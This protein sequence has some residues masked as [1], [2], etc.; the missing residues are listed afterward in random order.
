MKW[1][2]LLT[3]GALGLALFAAHADAHPRTSVSLGINLGAPFYRPWY[4]PPVYY[5]PYPIYYAPA[6][7]V[8]YEPAPIV[9][10]PAPIVVTS[11]PATVAAP[12]VV[13]VPSQVHLTSSSATSV[14]A[15][16]QLLSHGD[17]AVRRDAVMELGRQKA[18]N[19]VDAL[20]A[21]LAGDRSPIVRDAAARALGLIGS[22]RALTALMHAGQADS[23]RDVRRS[24]QF[25]VE[26]IQTN[27]RR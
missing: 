3:T 10:Q 14:Q 4:G 11:P 22:P 26:V 18:D 1:I 16:V 24:A 20:T 6:P 13:P 21:T 15:H 5:R 9:V 19:A 23:D 17:E 12:Q 8:I 2:Q 27:N 7:R 25:A